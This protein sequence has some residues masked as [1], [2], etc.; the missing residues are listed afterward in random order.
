MKKI[1]LTFLCCIVITGCAC[2]HD[3][4]CSKRNS[5]SLMDYLYPTKNTHIDTPSIPTLSLPL[6]IGVA[7][8][9]ENN[10]GYSNLNF[11]E[12]AKVDLL[13]KVSQ[14][15]KQY[16]F[17]K[18]IEIIPSYYLTKEG[19]FT[20]LSQVAN[21]FGTDVIALVSYDQVQHTNEGLLSI[22][23]WTIAGA[24]IFPGE[25]NDT[26]TLIDVAVYHVPSKKLLLRAPGTSTVKGQ[27]TLV[28]AGEQLR[29][30]AGKG[31]ELASEQLIPN[32]QA[33]LE[34]FKEKVKQSPQDYKIIHKPGYTGAGSI[35]FMN[36]FILIGLL[37]AICLCTRK[38]QKA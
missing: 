27:S 16:P 3:G 36:I 25:K 29:K 37:G 34:K 21:M 23:Y 19:G 14:Q 15:F 8:V 22:T 30:D 17:I 4:K 10:R 6:R 20:N 38:N 35:S 32:L 2:M 18:S 5:S 9:P 12:Q 13:N 7:F 1:L 24:Y 11:S 33:E 31:M 26:S 28:N